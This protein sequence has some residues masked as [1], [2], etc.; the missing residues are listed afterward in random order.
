LSFFLTVTY[1]LVTI[2]NFSMGD[3]IDPTIILTDDESSELTPAPVI[4]APET[5]TTQADT[6]KSKENEERL[7]HHFRGWTYSERSRDT[8]SWIWQF[9]YD[10]QRN[11][12]RKWV[13]RAC[14]RKKDPQPK[15]VAAAGTQN[16]ANHLWQAH[17]ISDPSG[18]K[19]SLAQR[20]EEGS[21][22]RPRSIVDIFKFDPTK[23]REQALANEFIKRFDKDQFQRLLV[24]WIVESNLPFRESENSRLR[25][26][27]D[28]LNPSVDV[29]QANITHN[30]VRKSVITAYEKHKEKVV[31]VLKK[32]PGL[33]HISFDG[34]RSRNR[35]SMYGTACFFRDENNRPCKIVLGV[36]EVV[37]RHS[38][39]NIA[40]E[41]LAVIDSFEISDK[42]GYFTLDNADNNDTA[43]EAIGAKLGFNGA[44]RRGR[45]FGHTLNLAAKAI[46]FGKSADAFEEQ[47]SGVKPLSEDEHA[48]W[49]KKGPVGKLHNLIIAVNRSDI[50]TYLLRELQQA[51]IDASTNAKVK[52]KKPLDVVVD[53][54]TRWLSQLYM[55]RRALRL[56][57]YFEQ[58]I[59]KHKQNWERENKSKRTGLVRK[60]ATLPVICQL[61]NQLTDKDWEVLEIFA[62]LLTNFEDAVKT[63]EGDGIVR[64]RKRG[65]VGS[66][67][68]P[69]DVII[70][71][72]FLLGKLEKYKKM[73]ETF[74]EPE[75]F[76]V[77]I[78][79]GWEKLEKYYTLLDET[80][81][82]YTALALHPAYRWGYFESTWECHPEWVKRA[83]DMVQEVWDTEYK[84]LNVVR[85]LETDEPIAKRQKRYHNAFE[86]HREQSRYMPSTSSIAAEVEVG[87]DEYEAWCST[88]EATDTA[89]RDPIAY[90][91]DKRFQYPRLSRMALDFL[92]IQPMSAECERL[93]SAAGLMVTPLRN[94][95]EANTIEICQVLRSWLRAGI[96]DEL[97]PLLVSVIEEEAEALNVD[98]VNVRQSAWLK[99]LP[100]KQAAEEAGWE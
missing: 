37:S 6:A 42:I 26:I 88:W 11:G 15:S 51:D 28:Y 16:A 19:I 84:G 80:P 54:D 99:S 100:A 34:W 35:H 79:L 40:A 72:E 49:R 29:C 2:N 10:I 27:F 91:H 5:P 90:W 81:I 1:Y 41:V 17:K 32:S 3:F 48:L 46:L 70:G 9:G 23:P 61:E 63:L 62:E 25:A 95:L 73:A 86:E 47:L 31:G 93:F 74:P 45:C 69:W 38:G 8:L 98:E 59:L 97:D 71:F 94:Q 78:N 52:S 85:G 36:P 89:V 75:H 22:N 30:T 44:R 87:R 92:T 60:S 65:W 20:K 13:C 77:N 55:I 67:G 76:R 43:M 68:N 14:I 24:E 33:L 21:S 96:I 39:S 7:F 56:R 18:K 50:L 53:N 83:K 57:G 82:Y 58:M 64:K 4:P 66:Y 12:E